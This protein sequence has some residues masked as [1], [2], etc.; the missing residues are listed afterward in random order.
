MSSCLCTVNKIKAIEPIAKA[1]RI[2]LANI[3]DWWC[4]VAKDAFQV[5]DL[6]L[7]VPPDSILPSKMIEEHK[8]EFLKKNGRVGVL[9]MR[10]VVSYGLILPNFGNWKEGQEMSAELGITKWEEPDVINGPNSNRPRLTSKKKLNPNF[11][12]YCDVENSKNFPDVFEEG[13][14]VVVTEKIH[15]ANWRAGWLKR[16]VSNPFEW[17]I[18]KLFGQYEFVYG[19][20]T[21][22]ISNN[23]NYKGFYGEDVY[24]K[25]A[26][27]YRMLEVCK[28]YPDMEF[29]A[30][31]YGP[32]I[33]DLTYGA[34]EVEL[35]F[36]DIKDTRDNTYLDFYQFDWIIQKENLPYAPILYIGEF[37]KLGIMGYANGDSLIASENGVTQ[38]REGVV[39]KTTKEKTC[40][41]GRKLLKYINSDYYTRPNGTEL[42]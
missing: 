25:A 22:Q 35:A 11:F 5:G 24:G 8:L 30:E 23:T 32:K 17:V 18:A 20:R 21:V 27:K 34:K 15:G 9:K 13:E 39:V 10:G 28:R 14:A 41:I 12:K 4:I 42:K 1:D 40:R 19:S 37:N 3:L 29:F 2:V 16:K 6:A 7:Y 36:F 31:L 26:K 38:I 33:Q